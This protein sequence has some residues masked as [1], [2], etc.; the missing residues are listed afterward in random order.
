MEDLNTPE[1]VFL[2]V[3]YGNIR[4]LP[5]GEHGTHA[6]HQ[7][8]EEALTGRPVA[9]LGGH[10]VVCVGKDLEDAMGLAEGAEN[11]AKTIWLRDHK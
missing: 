9:L 8:I 5:Y 10:G 2:H 6:I 7:G 11:F 3:I 1:D 4:C